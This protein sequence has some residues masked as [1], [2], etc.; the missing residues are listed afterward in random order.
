LKPLVSGSGNGV[1][2]GKKR[3]SAQPTAPQQIK[4]R[5]ALTS[6]ASGAAHE[7][8]PSISALPPRHD[9]LRGGVGALS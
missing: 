7:P 3:Y 2:F 4:K 5:T 8:H 9:L 6:L 1:K